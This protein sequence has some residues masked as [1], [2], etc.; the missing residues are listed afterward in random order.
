MLLVIIGLIRAR[1]IS[2]WVLPLPVVGIA[3]NA[4]VGTLVATLIADLLLLAAGTWIAI[5]IARFT[6][7]QWLGDTPVPVRL[8]DEPVGV[9]DIA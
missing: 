4:V 3:V 6:R 1:L 5:R 8:R 2:A 7:R 9:A